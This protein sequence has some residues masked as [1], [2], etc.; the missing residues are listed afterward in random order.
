[1]GLFP[2]NLPS[3]EHY[4]GR[5]KPYKDPA[6]GREFR[7]REEGILFGVCSKCGQVLQVGFNQERLV[8]ISVCFNRKCTLKGIE[9]P[10]P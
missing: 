7:R 9:Q 3:R 8:H 2:R 10:S 6:I 1:M 4:H 5:K